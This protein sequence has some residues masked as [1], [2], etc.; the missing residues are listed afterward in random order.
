[1]DFHSMNIEEIKESAIEALNNDNLDII[2]SF[3]EFELEDQHTDIADIGFDLYT[4]A[5]RYGK[6][7]VID[8]M[9]NWGYGVEWDGDMQEK[10]M[11]SAVEGEQFDLITKYYIT[12]CDAA[13]GVAYWAI[14]KDLTNVFKT[15]LEHGAYE[16]NNYRRVIKNPEMLIV[17]EDFLKK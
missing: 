5:H 9:C 15:C 2:E 17:L 16:H 3:C 8:I 13:N 4:L 12:D 7:K 6:E 10:S 14:S 11:D 1:M